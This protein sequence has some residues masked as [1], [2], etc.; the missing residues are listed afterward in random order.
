MT[1]PLRAEVDKPSRSVQ[2]SLNFGKRQ[3]NC[4]FVTSDPDRLSNHSCPDMSSYLEMPSPRRQA[5]CAKTSADCTTLPLRQS[6][7][8][9]TVKA[10]LTPIA[11]RMHEPSSSSVTPPCRT[12]PPADSSHL[13]HTLRDTVDCLEHYRPADSEPCRLPVCHSMDDSSPSRFSASD[14]FHRY[15]NARL[16][17]TGNS[18]RDRT[19]YSDSKLQHFRDAR[20]RSGPTEVSTLTSSV[21]HNRSPARCRSPC[22]APSV[23]GSVDTLSSLSS[24]STNDDAAFRAGLAQ[25]DANIALVQ[26][27]LRGSMSSLPSACWSSCANPDLHI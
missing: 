2:R 17:S 20:Y 7:G 6:V 24:M 22:S 10:L 19:P 3:L 8:S 4:D 23:E 21:H 12:C 18:V 13:D 11:Q 14:Y 1:P 9:T 27:R 26:Q 15:P 5:R 16:D 25:L